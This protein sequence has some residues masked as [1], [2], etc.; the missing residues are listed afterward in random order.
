M[1][2]PRGRDGSQRSG[3]GGCH[4]HGEECGLSNG[5]RSSSGFKAEERQ[6]LTGVK[7]S[8]GL[9]GKRAGEEQV[10]K[11]SEKI[12]ARTIN[13]NSD[14]KWPHSGEM[15]LRQQVVLIECF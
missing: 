2:Q 15:K 14:K 1:G 10:W 4:R 5:C 3:H 6:D 8:D 13:R 12:Q 11:P 9:G 7:G